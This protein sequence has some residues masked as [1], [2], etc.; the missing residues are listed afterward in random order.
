MDA[1]RLFSVDGKAVAVT[2]GSRG[3]GAMI[4]EGFVSAGARVYITARKAQACD[5][6]AERLGA[7]S[8]PAD[9]STVE[10]R[11]HFA[12]E[13]GER[14]DAL[15]VLVNNAG[16]TWGAPLDEFPESGW[17]KVIGVNLKGLFELTR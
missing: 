11:E 12:S 9:L 16:A 5:E 17:D 2:G 10:G 3:I 7:T 15:H 6:T 4:A 8:L 1:G 13:L 14:E